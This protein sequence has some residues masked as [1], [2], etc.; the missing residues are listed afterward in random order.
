MQAVQQLPFVLV[1]PLH[2]DVKH[3]VGV[4]LHLVLLFEIGCKLQ[5]V[6]LKCEVIPSHAIRNEQGTTDNNRPATLA[7]S[8]SHLFDFGNIPNEGIVIH[9]L[10]KLLQLVQVSD[11]VFTNPLKNTRGTVGPF[12]WQMRH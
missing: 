3:G 6:L 5:L 7:I 10:Q 8:R 9:K 11:V 1:D 4:D 12:I 2:L